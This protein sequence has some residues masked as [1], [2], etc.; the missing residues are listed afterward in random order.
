MGHRLVRTLLAV[1]LV[2]VFALAG[3]GGSDSSNGNNGGTL[4]YWASNQGSS[5][6]DDQR[7]LTPELEKFT[8]QTGVKVNLEVI[9]W[10]DLYKRILTAVSSGQNPD[11]LNI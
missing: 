3:C 4:T 5:L 6:Q 11:V 2:G 7:I 9:P 1:S 8:K 10:S